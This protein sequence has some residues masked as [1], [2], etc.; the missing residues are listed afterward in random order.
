MIN[1]FK[2]KGLKLFY[3]RGD[4]SKFP[5]EQQSRIKFILGLL[6][7]AKVIEDIDVFQ[8]RLHKLKGN[9]KGFWA[10]TVRAQ[11]RIIFRFENGTAFDVNYIDYH[12]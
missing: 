2:H 10:V 6:D 8:L 5:K 1:N 4:G 11:W 3:E 7:T 12:N 9:F